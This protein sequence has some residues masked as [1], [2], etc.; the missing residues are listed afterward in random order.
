VVSHV[1]NLVVCRDIACGEK[2]Y[3]VTTMDTGMHNPLNI[4]SKLT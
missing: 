3:T 1:F 4:F 2:L